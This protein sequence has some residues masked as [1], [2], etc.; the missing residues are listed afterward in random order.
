IWRALALSETQDAKS[1]FVEC[2]RRFRFMADMPELRAAV[3]RAV[4]DAWGRLDDFN[5]SATDLATRSPALTQ[6]LARVT[7]AWPQRLSGDALW[8]PA[9]RAAICADPLLRTLM[10]SA[11]ICDIDLEHFLT[12]VRRALLVDAL[13]ATAATPIQSPLLDFYCTLARQSFLN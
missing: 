9:E 6:S 7:A 12:S 10:E 5:A 13:A 1:V 11:P 4:A 2:L 8:T 3:A